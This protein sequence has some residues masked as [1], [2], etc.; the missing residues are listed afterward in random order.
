MAHVWRSPKLAMI[1]SRARLL[2]LAVTVQEA[3]KLQTSNSLSHS[4]LNACEA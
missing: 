2:A 1:R 4:W 3:G